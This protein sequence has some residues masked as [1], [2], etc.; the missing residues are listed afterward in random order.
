MENVRRDVQNVIEA[1]GSRS[2]HL[3]PVSSD[4]DNED[5]RYT[6]YSLVE[7]SYLIY[8]T[9]CVYLFIYLSMFGTPEAGR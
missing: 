8:T 4:A 3:Q 1:M 6:S 2:P 7:V 9:E 5:S